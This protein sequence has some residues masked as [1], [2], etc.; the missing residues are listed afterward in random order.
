MKR[1]SGQG[2]AIVIAVGAV[3]VLALLPFLFGRFALSRAQELA[4]RHLHSS[5][6]A[7]SCSLGWFGGLQCEQIR[8]QDSE[9]G[10]RFE[11]SKL[12]SDKGVLL[13]LAAPSY[14]GD[15]TVEQPVLT[16]LSPLP[17]PES[18]AD[19]GNS[20]GTS[21]PDG[22]NQQESRSSP[23]WERLTFRFKANGGQIAI[24]H[25]ADPPR[26]IARQFEFDGSLVMGSVHY[27]LS[28][29]SS[30]QTGRFRA[31]GFI[32][33]PLAGQPLPEMLVTGADV[34]IADLEIADFLQLAASRSQM[35]SGRGTLNATL[36]LNIA[37]IREFE[38]SGE[39]T[40]RDVQL[41][42]GVLGEDH[43]RL[44]ELDFRFAG[45]YRQETGWRLDT[46]ELRS[47]PAHFKAK[48]GF[49]AGIGNLSA[50]GR[51]HLP[52]L[53]AQVPRLLKVHEQTMI[54]EG[55]V[56]FSLAATG[57]GQAVTIRTDCRTEHLSLIH[58]GRSYSWTLPLSFAAE[59]DYSAGST[60][61]RSLRVHT[62]FFEARGGGAIDGFFL[63]A[64]GD[65][66]RMSQE[67]NTIFD[68]DVQ[69]KGRFELTAA[70]RKAAREGID[71]E[72]RIAIGN[73]A[74]TRGKKT[75]LPPHDLLISGQAV[76]GPSFLQDRI[77]DSLQVEASAWPGSFSF[78]MRT[79]DMRHNMADAEK[80]CALRGHVDLERLRDVIQ[81]LRDDT[82]LP[83][84]QGAL[85][86]DGAGSCTA[87]AKMS[88][89]DMQ[90]TIERLAV[91]GPGYAIREPHVRFALGGTGQP[92]G[93]QVGLRELTVVASQQDLEPQK[94]PVFQVDGVQRRLNVQGLGWASAETNLT[95]SGTIRDWQRPTAGFSASFRGE[96][97]AAL[98][99]DLARGRG[100][101]PADMGLA[102]KARGALTINAGAGHSRSEVTLDLA[103]FS[104]MSGKQ[105]LFTDP[106]P[107]V[108]LVLDQ[109]D[110][111]GTTTKIPSLMLRSTPFGI[112]GAGS[113]AATVPPMLELR[114]R[115]T[116]DYAALLP[117]LAPFPGLDLSMSSTRAADVLISLPLQW[118]VP[119]ERLTFSAQLPVDSLSLQGFGFKPLVV[120]VD[121]NMGRLRCRLDGP[122]EG[123]GRAAL[124]PVWHL[125]GPQ[126][127]LSLPAKDQLVQDAPL[128]PALVKLLGRL[129]PLFGPV[130]QPQGAVTMR[131]KSFS[132]P[133]AGKGTQWPAFTLALAMNQAQFKPTGALHE[134]LALAGITQERVSCREQEMICEGKKGRVRCDAIYLLAGD[135]EISLQGEMLPNGLL[136]YRI[137]LPV[138]QQLM[139]KTG[140]MVQGRAMVE[141]EIGG[142]RNNPV[143]DAAAFL[144]G[145]PAQLQGTGAKQ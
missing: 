125:A 10:L 98:L 11:A 71:C 122:L 110:R 58:G 137:R 116:C 139:E 133:P 138:S 17:A 1:V 131:L 34:T 86:F 46:L 59:A 99:G 118:P 91:I 52:V 108:H 113:I 109:E 106:H 54:N 126:T 103:S 117:V 38:A 36:R 107:V 142:D 7:G 43:P 50:T 90:G 2:R 124:E 53:A 136:R 18:S 78:S 120:P 101:L 66:D 32:N 135:H 24:A 72:G 115:M 31:K 88:L 87:D 82:A 85:G 62:P 94:S 65:L 83:A 57:N 79:G 97:Q 145:L 47:E 67:L 6:E 27:D 144:A 8:Y 13:L 80:N 130:A 49:N 51:L 22:D 39:T 77:F 128:K 25:N 14:L 104:V 119:M 23:W 29:L 102:G 5:L 95:I 61:V 68:L 114:G 20:G 28:F 41:S 45:G 74:W 143:F 15:I 69:A 89:R 40:L 111:P 134:L 44:E 33:L 12:T 48:G 75:P 63:E 84:L 3:T 127:A 56:D 42:G 100:W 92:S 64:S 140:L 132:L 30:Q 73:F 76:V 123:G 121:C 16:V 9:R 96:T 141:A 81:G 35:P 112:E 26:Q 55:A 21:S 70:T 60:A 19:T 4:A 105:K 93:R 129:H 37:G